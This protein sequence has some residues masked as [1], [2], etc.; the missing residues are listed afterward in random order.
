MFRRTPPRPLRPTVGNTEGLTTQF[1][2]RYPMSVLISCGDHFI[3]DNSLLWLRTRLQDL[4]LRLP[5]GSIRAALRLPQL[6]ISAQLFWNAPV[7]GE[8][9]PRIAYGIAYR[10]TLRYCIPYHPTVLHTVSPYG[11][12]YRKYQRPGDNPVHFS[13]HPQGEHPQHLPSAG[14]TV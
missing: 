14:Q 8:S 9:P 4:T 13:Q 6:L 5:F 2:G 3:S 12:A 11:I 7:P 1:S 10:I